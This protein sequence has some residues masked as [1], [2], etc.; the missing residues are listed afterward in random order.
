MIRFW[1]L[2]DLVE[3]SKHV[4]SQ[5]I[6]HTLLQGSLGRLLVIRIPLKVVKCS[7]ESPYHN[8]KLCQDREN[9][10]SRAVTLLAGATHRRPIHQNPTVE[11]MQSLLQVYELNLRVSDGIRAL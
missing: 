4:A 10:F 7:S 3:Y 11:R 2:H 1:V 9:L 8:W 6:S 5:G